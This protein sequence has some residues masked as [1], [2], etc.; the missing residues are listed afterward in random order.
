MPWPNLHLFHSEKSFWYLYCLTVFWRFS[1]S[2]SMN[3][4]SWNKEASSDN[5]GI[6]NFLKI[7]SSS[8]SCYYVFVTGTFWDLSPLKLKPLDYSITVSFTREGF[9]ITESSLLLFTCSEF[10]YSCSFKSSW[11]EE[12]YESIIVIF[13][14]ANFGFKIFFIS[15]LTYS[16]V[17][18]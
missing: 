13:S 7:A 16:L 12:S 8:S 11:D 9:S 18:F 1:F 3:F 10:R 15:V 17:L 14:L 5:Q 2:E 6:F 4:P